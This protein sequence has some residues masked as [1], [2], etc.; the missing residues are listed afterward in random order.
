MLMQKMKRIFSDA[1]IQMAV[2]LK[3]LDNILETASSYTEG[4]P[5]NITRMARH[6]LW[7]PASVKAL[8]GQ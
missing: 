3:I 4:K 5:A 8:F 2:F 7:L 6:Q 1:S